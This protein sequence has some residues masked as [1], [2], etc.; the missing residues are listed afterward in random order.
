MDIQT[1]WEKVVVETITRTWKKLE[2]MMCRM[3]Q[4]SRMKLSV[5]KFSK[6]SATKIS[7]L[8]NGTFRWASRSWSKAKSLQIGRAHV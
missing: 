2:L 3:L 7:R 4:L 8:S 6:L 1:G 5:L